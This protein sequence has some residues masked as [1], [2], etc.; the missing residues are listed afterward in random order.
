MK[1][2]AYSINQLITHPAYLIA[3]EP[4][5]MHFG[6]SVLKVAKHALIA[7]IFRTKKN[8]II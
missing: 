8:Y 5:H 6:I 4:K 7:H 1:K 2:I 3:R